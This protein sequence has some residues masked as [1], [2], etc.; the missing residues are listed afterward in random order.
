VTRT[1]PWEPAGG[2]ATAAVVATCR[3]VAAELAP[4]LP[5]AAARIVDALERCD[6]AHS[7]TLFRKVA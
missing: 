6:P 3:V 2:A 4:F 1:R 5:A 7:R